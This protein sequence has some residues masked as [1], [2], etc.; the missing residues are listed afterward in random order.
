L[1][2]LEAMNLSKNYVDI[3]LTEHDSFLE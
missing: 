1:T 2:H 3:K